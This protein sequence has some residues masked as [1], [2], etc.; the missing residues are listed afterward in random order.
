MFIFNIYIFI[1]ISIPIICYNKEILYEIKLYFAKK[2]FEKYVHDKDW[3][4][5]AK[6]AEYCDEK[7]LDILVN[8]EEKCVRSRVV[9]RGID[10]YLNILVYDESWIVRNRVAQQIIDKYLDILVDDESEDVRYSVADY[11]NLEHCK[12]LLQDKN[13]KVR[14][15]AYNKIKEI[16]YSELCQKR[17][18]ERKL[19]QEALINNEINNKP[20]NIIQYEIIQ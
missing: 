13:E 18:K 7:Y 2:N 11:G 19:K 1:V 9:Q 20:N 8:D 6:V 4:I 10:K 5:R 17:N 16:E 3:R 14:N 15:R 12:K